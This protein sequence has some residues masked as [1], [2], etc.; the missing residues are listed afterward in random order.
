CAVALASLEI[1]RSERTLERVAATSARLQARLA[2]EVVPLPHVGDV[3]QQGLMVGIELVADAG[4]RTPYPPAARGGQRVLQGARR[5]GV[6]ARPLG[7]VIVLMPPLA[8]TPDELE[9]LVDV[10]RDAIAEVT[11]V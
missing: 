6:I 11:G 8:I 1:F 10:A 4:R 3:R 2:N 9:Q 7:S 5:R